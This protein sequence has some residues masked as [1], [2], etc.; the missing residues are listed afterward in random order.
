MDQSEINIV[1]AIVINRSKNND[2]T[3][4]C[5]DLSAAS[6][7]CFFLIAWENREI[8]PLSLI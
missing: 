5:K 8:L 2:E 6:R 1:I 3:A 4:E 7:H